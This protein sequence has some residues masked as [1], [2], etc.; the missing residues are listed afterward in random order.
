MFRLAA[1]LFI[2]CL[3]LCG[4]AG[5]QAKRPAAAAQSLRS[6]TVATEPGAAVWIDSVL[7]GKTGTDGK[8]VIRS[9]PAG[10]RTLR[11]LH[12]GSKEFRK[13]LGPAVK[14]EIAVKL[15]PTTDPAELAYQEAE[16]MTSR[17]RQKAIA[18]FEKAIS[19]RPKFPEAYL[20]L[21]RTLSES[22]DFERADKTIKALKKIKLVYPEA[23]A[24]EGRIYKDVAEEAKAVATF[25]RAITEG[26]GFQPEAYTGLGLLYKEKAE[27]AG[28]A[29]DY[30]DESANY[31]E[32]A[33]YLAAA[34]K[35]LASA[36]DAAVVYQLLGLTYEKQKRFPEAIRVYQEFLRLFPDSPEATA[37]QSFIDQIRK[38][39][40]EQ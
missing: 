20:G 32:S 3:A 33:K 6:I 26:G 31:T 18:A 4:V 25:K 12:D 5:G 21:A 17:D 39:N 29:G 15:T 13:L 30:A 7:F 11:V 10:N 40:R 24:V 27:N 23:S 28:S 14:G 19:L 9:V 22:G 37:V 8:L 16:R 34:A 2:F 38:Q 36:P 35:Q 1:V